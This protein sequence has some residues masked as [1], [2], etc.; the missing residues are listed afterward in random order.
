MN[1]PCAAH[2]SRTPALPHRDLACR[3]LR[4]LRGRF[5]PVGGRRGDD[6][7]PRAGYPKEARAPDHAGWGH[8]ARQSSRE[9]GGCAAS[10]DELRHFVLDV[11]EDLGDPETPV[12]TATT[13][14]PSLEQLDAET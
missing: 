1:P 7:P 2:C 3:S 8:A 9:G 12:A 4:M 10:P 5:E 14:M 11:D 6:R 13:P